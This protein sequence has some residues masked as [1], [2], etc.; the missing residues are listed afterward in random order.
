MT[1]DIGDDIEFTHE[2]SYRLALESIE[3]WGRNYRLSPA[4]RLRAI[5]AVVEAAL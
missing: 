3:R 4:L 5:K 1:S 2:E